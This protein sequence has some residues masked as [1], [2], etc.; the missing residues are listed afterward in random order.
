MSKKL[1]EKEEGFLN[2]YAIWRVIL[3]KSASGSSDPSILLLT[4]NSRTVLDTQL[5]NE[6]MLATVS[7]NCKIHGLLHS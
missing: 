5:L 6:Q 1:R 4:Q 2:T 7:P 3:A